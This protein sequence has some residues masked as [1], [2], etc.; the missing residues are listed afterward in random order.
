MRLL[1]LLLCTLTLAGEKRWSGA[2]EYELANRI[3]TEADAA[4]RIVL[5]GE[6]ESTYPRTDFESER[7]LLFAAAYRDAGDTG[8]AF[9]RAT[10]MLNADPHDAAALLFVAELGPSLASPSASQIEAVA[11]AAMKLL[12]SRGQGAPQRMAPPAAATDRETERVNAYIRHMRRNTG[13]RHDP[14][15][16]KRRVAERAVEWVNGVR[17]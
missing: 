14:E 15:R 17:R 3:S 10:R 16:V 1:A 4:R 12:A 9:A 7:Q 8:E 5:L 13:D 2:A 11:A 6:W